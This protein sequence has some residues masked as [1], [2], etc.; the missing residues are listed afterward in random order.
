MSH[1]S[2]ITYDEIK[3]AIKKLKISFSGGKFNIPNAFFIK[4][5]DIL[6]PFLLQLFNLIFSTQEIPSAWKISKIFPLFKKGDRMKI[7]NY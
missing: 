7:E 1:I 3:T 5:M 4:L 6:L 2:V